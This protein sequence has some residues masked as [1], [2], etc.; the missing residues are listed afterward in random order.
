MVTLQVTP[1]GFT[2]NVAGFEVLDNEHCVTTHV[3][4]APFIAAEAFVIV[5][6]LEVAPAISNYQRLRT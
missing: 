4:D 3:N 6:V 2:V 1:H 5:K